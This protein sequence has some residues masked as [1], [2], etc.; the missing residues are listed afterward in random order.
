MSKNN[1]VMYE[2]S[3]NSFC[4][5]DASTNSLAFALFINQDLVKYGKIRFTGQSIYE[6]IGDTSHKTK[7][8]FETIQTEH[9]IIEKTIFANSA[10]VAAN[11]ALSQ[12]ALIGAAKLAGVKNIYGIAPIAWQSYIGNRLLTTDEKKKIRDKNPDKSN[13][14]YKAQEREQRKRKTINVV[15]NKFDINVDDNDIADA[16][17][18]GIFTID[19]W[20]KVV[21]E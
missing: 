9:I 13:S 15:N 20:A 18:I 17:G 14:W 21:R 16:C 3:P 19:N 1:N 8:F 7:A 11:L 4:A 2:K 6:K 5:I 10:Q 12:G